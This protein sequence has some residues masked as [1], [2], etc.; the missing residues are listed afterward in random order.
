M[1]DTQDLKSC[2][3][4]PSCGFESRLSYFFAS[5]LRYSQAAVHH[6]APPFSLQAARGE[7]PFPRRDL[8]EAVPGR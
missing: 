8:P 4:F 6:L 2:E 3:G 7:Y 1:A 5:P